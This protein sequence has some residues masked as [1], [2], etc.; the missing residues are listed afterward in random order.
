MISSKTSGSPGRSSSTEGQGSEGGRALPLRPLGKALPREEL[1]R[2]EALAGG[3]GP[4]IGH[5]HDVLMADPVHRACLR[6]EARGRLGIVGDVAS[7][8]LQR[9]MP[10]Q[11]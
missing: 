4:E 7:E 8:D 2:E 3:S 5:V 11:G 6:E 9:D 10:L 1:H